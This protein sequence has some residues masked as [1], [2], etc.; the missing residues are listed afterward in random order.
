MKILYIAGR[1]ESY[2]RTR[3]VQQAL[4]MQGLE[5]KGYSRP[6]VLSSIIRA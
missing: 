4:R 6:I 1:E 5:V 2:S 3:I